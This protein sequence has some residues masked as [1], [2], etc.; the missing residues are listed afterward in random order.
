MSS[1]SLACKRNID[2]VD[3]ILRDKACFRAHTRL[4]HPASQPSPD[5]I[6]V[7]H[8]SRWGMICG[9]FVYLPTN[10]WGVCVGTFSRVWT[11]GWDAIMSGAN[12]PQSEPRWSRDGVSPVQRQLA[13]DFR[14]SVWDSSRLWLAFDVCPS[15]LLCHGVTNINI[16]TADLLVRLLFTP[17][18]WGP[19]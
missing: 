7:T 5:S 2:I 9:R 4:S 10:E 8:V 17:L 11:R 13:L 15:H 3:G 12:K 1:S 14:A 16:L 6:V 18:C 19:T